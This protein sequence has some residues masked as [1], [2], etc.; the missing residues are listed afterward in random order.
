[1]P[2][3]PNVVGAAEAAEILGVVVTSVTRLKKNGKM[4]ALAAD[5]AAT[6]VWHRKD[7]E[8]LANTG[9]IATTAK[10][11]DLMGTAEAAKLIDVDKSQIG[12]WHRAGKFPEPAI[13]LAAGPVWWREQIE[14]R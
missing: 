3:K 1:M 11:L 4:P 8:R 5:L 9:K 10:P 13:Q 12:R 6:P 2:R 14:N 7:I